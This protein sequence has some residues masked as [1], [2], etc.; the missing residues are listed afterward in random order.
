MVDEHDESTIDFLADRAE[1]ASLLESAL[2]GFADELDALDGAVPLG[3][4]ALDIQN[5]QQKV[6]TAHERNSTAHGRSPEIRTEVSTGIAQRLLGNGERLPVDLPGSVDELKTWLIDQENHLAREAARQGFGFL[7]L[8]QELGEGEF[9]GW[10]AEHDFKERRVYEHIAIAQM[11]LAAPDVVRPQ[12]MGMSKKKLIEL[13]RLPEETIAE[14]AATGVLDDLGRLSVRELKEEIRHLKGREQS[15]AA[16]LEA[17]QEQNETL[18]VQIGERRQQEG[19]GSFGTAFIRDTA[20]AED[21]IM[22]GLTELQQ[23]QAE[24]LV[25]PIDPQDPR[26]QRKWDA[27]ACHLYTATTSLYGRLRTLLEHLQ[28]DLPE[29]AKGGLALADSHLTDG[30]IADIVMV[31][32]S[33]TRHADQERS[34]KEAE[35]KLNAP[36]KRGRPAKTSN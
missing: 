34:L 28:L 12:L 35:A 23:L 31:R 26:A 2:D 21:W 17:A 29:S 14:A 20:L 19:L 11:L 5:E 16:D 1:N 9:A 22:R 6:A 32:Q 10:L 4:I 25:H 18:Q 27:V 3:K 24:L 15:I 8:K 36:R 7:V 33:Q 30:Q 13:A